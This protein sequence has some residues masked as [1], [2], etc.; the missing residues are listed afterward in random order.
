MAKK[1]TQIESTDSTKLFNADDYEAIEVAGTVEDTKG[2]LSAV[3]I[4]IEKYY[5]APDT[6]VMVKKTDAE[7]AKEVIGNASSVTSETV[8]V[9]SK[10][11]EEFQTEVVQCTEFNAV[12]QVCVDCENFTVD[13]LNE[14][15][16]WCSN[17]I[18]DLQREEVEA[19]EAEMRAIQDKLLA[20]K[21]RKP[22]PLTIVSGE[23]KRTANPI[24]NPDNPSQVYKFGRTP[25]WLAALMAKTGKTIIE[26]RNMA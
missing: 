23:A 15:I 8:Q 20:L 11:A 9:E 2:L 25:D 5:P 22:A 4:E 10:G 18:D 26:L 16:N 6:F 14:V 12:E 21:G 1:T 24:V 13:E 17:K 19:L 3:G 7:K